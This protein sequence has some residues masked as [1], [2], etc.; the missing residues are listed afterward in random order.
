MTAR[1]L[2]NERP[3]CSGARH[4]RRARPWLGTLVE[5]GVDAGPASVA[6]IEA[7]FRAVA[8]VQA[9]MSVFEPG[10]D[11]ARFNRAATGQ[12]VPVSAG[13][14]EVLSCCAELHERTHGLF[15]VALGSGRWRLE[16][17]AT[18]GEAAVLVKIDAAARLDLG[19]I[20][21]GHAVDRALEAALAAGAVQVWVNAGGDLRCQGLEL[22][23]AL[24]DETAGG[25]R[26]FLMLSDGAL[27][28]SCFGPQARS[29][30]YR[31]LRTPGATGGGS[32]AMGVSVAAPR[33]LW[34]DALTKV[35]AAQPRPGDLPLLAEYGATGWW[36]A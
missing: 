29:R 28:S 2:S 27:A 25:V 34:A 18:P 31:R 16:P 4:V 20:A 10:S 8:D 1:H 24:R 3:P 19:G 26:P 30:L 12:G 35:V 14:A 5:V 7:A 21:K 6:A 36:H 15:D 11:I 33:C 32:A 22:P 17:G 23:V 9:L 13:T